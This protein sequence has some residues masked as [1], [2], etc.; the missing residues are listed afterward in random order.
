[1]DPRNC[2]AGRSRYGPSDCRRPLGLWPIPRGLPS[3]AGGRALDPRGRG[4]MRAVRPGRHGN[5]P[6]APLTVAKEYAP[7]NG[8]GNRRGDAGRRWSSKEARC[9]T[10]RRTP[11]T[12][13]RTNPRVPRL[14]PCARAA[15][16]KPNESESLAAGSLRASR[17][18]ENRTNP[19][20]PAVASL[21][22][23]RQPGKPNEPESPA[24]ASWPGCRQIDRG[25]RPRKGSAGPTAGARGPHCDEVPWTS[26]TSRSSA[27]PGTLC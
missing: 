8:L 24:V 7:I 14:P 27:T 13:N 12:E 1:M 2:L 5:R 10:G 11:H 15:H 21:R 6:R 3:D 4:E 17:Q 9:R 16:G 22:A 25:V 18:P 20:S 26:P 19:R 23:S